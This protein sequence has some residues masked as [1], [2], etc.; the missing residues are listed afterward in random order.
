MHAIRR[1]AKVCGCAAVISTILVCCPA[2]A[3]I[4]V[5][6][7][8]GDGD[9]DNNGL[10]SGASVTDST[11]IGIPWL[12]TDGTSAIT[13]KAVDDSAGIG[14][15][16]AMQLFN[17]GANNRPSVGH[18]AAQTLA[19]GDQL[20][21]RFDLRLLSTTTAA[22]VS[23]TADRAIRFGLYHDTNNDD[24]TVDHGSTGS[25]SV[26]DVGYNCRVDAAADVSNTTYMD[27]TRDDTATGTSIIQATTTGL[28][29]SSSN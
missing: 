21:L 6:D 19:D 11:D 27:V 4:I 23:T 8:F 13:F 14:S 17:T 9:R 5:S 15:A 2:H 7:G 26:D 1:S 10:D 18:F 22:L 28:S 20:I 16:N 3:A 24:G 12:L 25:L 29:I